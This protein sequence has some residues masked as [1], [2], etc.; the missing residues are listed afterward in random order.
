MPA[1]AVGFRDAV[2]V[3]VDGELETLGL[4]EAAVRAARG[5]MLVCHEPAVSARLET[6][7]LTRVLDVLDLYAFACP[8][9][10][11]LPT[12]GGIAAAL[13]LALPSGSLE[14]QA[15][16]LHQ[17]AELLLA[18]LADPRY[19]DRPEAQRLART[20]AKAGW[21]WG[22]WVTATLGAPVSGED[23]GS[24]LDVWRRLPQWEDA[25]PRPPPPQ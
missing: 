1:L 5:M 16:I 18:L 3:T 23:A 2:I 8:A 19:P 21:T 10:F 12:P 25:A 20:M 24:G 14:D 4:G 7:P 15:A 9:K 11:C 22:A 13:G 6:E 17:A